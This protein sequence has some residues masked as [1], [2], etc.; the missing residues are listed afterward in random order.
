[1]CFKPLISVIIP[2]YNAERYLRKCI[3]SVLNQSYDS[4]ELILI[5]DGSSDNS[6]LICEEYA[7]VN[8]NV[9]VA[10]TENMGVSSAR[11][12]GIRLCSGEYITFVDADDWV[13]SDYLFNFLKFNSPIDYKTLIFQGYLWESYDSPELSHTVSV[14]DYDFYSSS[15]SFVFENTKTLFMGVVCSKLYSSKIIKENNL[16]FNTKMRLNEDNCFMWE[17]MKHINRIICLP[18]EGYHYMHQK[19]INSSKSFKTLNEYSYICCQNI[20]C[21]EELYSQFSIKKSNMYD[22][23][24]SLYVLDNYITQFLCYNQLTVKTLEDDN[25]ILL[26][27]KA[28]KKYSLKY[29]PTSIKRRLVKLLFLV[30]NFLSVKILKKV[31]FL[32][33]K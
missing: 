26:T 27:I 20:V 5:N 16:C 12:L 15:F 19:D 33:L 4:L 11:N 14:G 10:H 24:F 32:I 23:I 7:Q 13:D 30:F 31:I 29:I 21:L 2:V 17:Y 3:D 28:F 18:Y 22:K 8:P 6:F 25:N 9:K 1:M